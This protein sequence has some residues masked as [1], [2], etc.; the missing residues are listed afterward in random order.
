MMHE[1][2]ITKLST[3]H[4]EIYHLSMFQQVRGILWMKV[5]TSVMIISCWGLY[6]VVRDDAYHVNINK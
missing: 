4:L 1:W 2:V 5:T 3:N 6:Y